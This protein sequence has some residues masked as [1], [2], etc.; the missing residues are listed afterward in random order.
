[1]IIQVT[2]HLNS[3]NLN[4]EIK[5]LKIAEKRIPNSKSLLLTGEVDQTINLPDWCDVMPI[6]TWLLE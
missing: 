2:E 3:D 4:R 6:C 5:G 1:L